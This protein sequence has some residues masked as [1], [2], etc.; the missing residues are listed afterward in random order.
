MKTMNKLK[1]WPLGLMVI[2]LSVSASQCMSEQHKQQQDEP[3]SKVLNSFI[4]ELSNRKELEGGANYDGSHDQTKARTFKGI[5]SK[6]G[7]RIEVA[8][9]LGS[10]F[11]QAPRRMADKHTGTISERLAKINS[12]VDTLFI[13]G[14][15]R[16]EVDYSAQASN[17]LVNLSLHYLQKTPNGIIV[18]IHGF[19]AEKRRT[20]KASSANFILSSGHRNAF[21]LPARFANCLGDQGFS[22]V[23]VYGK[24]VD[25][26]GAT[27]NVVKKGINQQQFHRFLHIEIGLKQRESLLQS[28]TRLKALSHCL[29]H[30]VELGD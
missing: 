26:L 6:H 16:R 20:L 14:R 23:L 18:Q 17:V 4:D 5:E 1:L 21:K 10:I 11:L 25:E 8:D 24:D 28:A 13:N 30:L 3:V 29:D 27:K 19:A 2:V 9:Q 22:D 15:H 12:H 7:D